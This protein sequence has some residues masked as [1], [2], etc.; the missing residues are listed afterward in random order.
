MLTELIPVFA[1]MCYGAMGNFAAF[2]E[3]AIA[4]L[5]DGNRKRLRLLPFNLLGFF[6]SLF[7]ISNSVAS[8][9]VDRIL[10]RGMV[11]EKTLRYRK[12]SIE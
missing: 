7:S 3:I 10:K 11:W 2:F 4:V 1:V 8:L 12:P 5:L 9:A 6:V